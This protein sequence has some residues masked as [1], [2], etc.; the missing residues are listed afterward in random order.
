MG[1][2]TNQ[3][4]LDNHPSIRRADSFGRIDQQAYDP[5]QP[6]AALERWGAIQVRSFIPTYAVRALPD[7]KMTEDNIIGVD[8]V[9]SNTSVP[10][11]V[12]AIS[13]RRG[14][15]LQAASA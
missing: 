3:W 10:A 2:G 14:S 11:D 15:W 4:M 9:S 7:W 8:Y 13:A 12:V 5:R 1:Y 6:N